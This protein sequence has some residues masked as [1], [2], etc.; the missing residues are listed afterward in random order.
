M[1]AVPGLPIASLVVLLAS[2]PQVQAQSPASTVRPGV[3]SGV[4]TGVGTGSTFR[5]MP[6]PAGQ[7]PIDTSRKF[8]WDTPESVE[9]FRKDKVEDGAPP[10]GASPPQAPAADVKEDPRT[11]ITRDRIESPQH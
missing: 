9:A 2:V 11:M 8:M 6:P 4:T 10:R 3:D 1:R 7:P 5:N